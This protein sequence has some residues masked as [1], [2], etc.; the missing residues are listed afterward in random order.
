MVSFWPVPVLVPEYNLREMSNTPL[1][2]VRAGGGSAY[3]SDFVDGSFVGIGFGFVGE[4]T[5]PIDKGELQARLTAMHPAMKPGKV[6]ME[7]SQVTR[8]YDELRVGDRVMTYDASQR[9]YFL[10]RIDSDV[11]HREHPLSR[12]RRVTWE[13]QTHRDALTQSTRNQLGAIMT[14]FL[15]KDDATAE[16]D[17]HAQPIGTDGPPPTAGENPPVP[18]GNGDEPEEFVPE[19]ADDV[20][21]RAEEL[22]DDL[23]AKLSWQEV[24]ELMAEILRAMGFRAEATAPGPDR[25]VDVTASPDGLGLTEPRIFVEVK[26]RPN[27]RMSA[28]D[29]RA[30][31]GGRQP[32]DR[33]LYLSTGGFTKEARYEAERSTIPLTLIDL[34]RLREL[35]LEHYERFSVEGLKLVPLR[36]VHWPV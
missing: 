7:V 13:R 35:V 22:I 26:H 33:C 15:V 1:W 23:L 21:A 8:F 6:Q 9:L 30:F 11:E 5:S 28:P 18:A 20:E 16:L 36:R 19:S 4:V 25:G 3:A 14:L 34:P 17:H 24:Q 27:N 2:M 10:G 31:L 32:G 12:A 29:L